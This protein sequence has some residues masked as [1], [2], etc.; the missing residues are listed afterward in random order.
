MNERD[1]FIN[2]PFSDDYTQFFHAIVYTVVR[3]GFTPRCARESDDGG[4]VRY[5]KICNIIRDCKFGIHDLSMT[6][7]DKQTVLPRFNMPFEL[8]LFLAASKFGGARS[9][10]STLILDRAQFRYREFLSDIAGQDIRA[11]DAKPAVAIECVAAWLRD[12]SNDPKVPGGRAIA[13]E[14]DRF[15]VALPR[16]AD[17]KQLQ[18]DE[19]TFRDFWSASAE[20]IA[21]EFPPGTPR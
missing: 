1:V 14:F 10:R 15:S 6:G 18:M 11:H 4:V 16:I 20:W 13:S 9:R 5:E 21:A 7:L 19:I 3:S 8:G 2:C 17:S 12:Q